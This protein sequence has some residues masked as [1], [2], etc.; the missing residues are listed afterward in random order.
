MTPLLDLSA[1]ANLLAIAPGTLRGHVIAGRIAHRRVGGLIRFSEAD[2]D[3]FVESC[4]VEVRGPVEPKV[5][6]PFGPLTR[7][8][9]PGEPSRPLLGSGQSRRGRK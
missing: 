1:A 7:V 4:R 8:R 2:L 5:V 9:L 3:E 6:R